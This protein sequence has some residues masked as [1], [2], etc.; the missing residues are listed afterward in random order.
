MRAVFSWLTICLF[1]HLLGCGAPQEP[2]LDAQST[3]DASVSVDDANGG[4]E[5]DA[6]A[7]DARMSGEACTPGPALRV[8]FVGNSQVQF[9]AL[10][11]IVASLAASADAS[12]PRITVGGVAVGG[13][14]LR[15]L[16]D[17]GRLEPAIRSGDYDVVV[18]AESIDLT[19]L[20]PDPFPAL[21]NEYARRIVSTAREVGVTPILFATPNVDGADR[22]ATFRGMADPQ[23][24]LGRE[25][26]VVV[27]TGGLAWLRAWET[28]PALDLHHTDRGHPNFVGSYLSA[29]VIYAA[30]LDARPVRLT[31]APATDCTDGPCTP[32]TPEFAVELQQIAW[33]E[34][35]ANGRR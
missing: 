15:D 23:L 22:L 5:T 17:T 1:T 35:L 10:P 9:W 26:N 28:Y 34:Y 29:L 31:N 20:A 19:F 6:N 14:S 24:A 11:H 4:I 7:P 33:D 12:C 21:F 8:L 32:I 2:T 13:A 18:I 30:I 25:L 3:L 27:A 16:W